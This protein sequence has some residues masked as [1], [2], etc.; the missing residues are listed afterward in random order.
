[1]KLFSK[2]EIAAADTDRLK[3]E[4]ELAEAESAR[5]KA[6]SKTEAKR[7]PLAEAFEASGDLALSEQITALDQAAEKVRDWHNQRVAAAEAR[8]RDAKERSRKAQ[9]AVAARAIV[10]DAAKRLDG[11]AARVANLAKASNAAKRA[12]AEVSA[13]LEVDASLER[14]PMLAAIHELTHGP[15]RRLLAASVFA[16]GVL[17]P[18]SRGCKDE[19][20]TARSV[21]V[22]AVAD[23][24]AAIERVERLSDAERY[25]RQDASR[26]VGGAIRESLIAEAEASCTPWDCDSEIRRQLLVRTGAVRRGESERLKNAEQA[27]LARMQ[28]VAER[29][30][31]SEDLSLFLAH[32]EGDLAAHP[33]IKARISAAHK[34]ATDAELARLL[35]AA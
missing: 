13:S 6:E 20:R 29:E 21:L 5:A 16:G 31:T 15:A 2:N 22:A 3:A 1:M 30:V 23:I 33:A 34:A 11:E 32:K 19:L 14:D 24:D 25:A 10:L 18:I 27:L 17:S 28:D 12:A 4:K 26:R 7:T 9:Q 8:L 35:G